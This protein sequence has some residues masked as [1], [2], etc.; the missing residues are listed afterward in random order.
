MSRRPYASSAWLAEKHSVTMFAFIRQHFAGLEAI[1]SGTLTAMLSAILA[2]LQSSA[3]SLFGVCGDD[4]GGDGTIDKVTNFSF[5]DVQP[6]FG[7]D[8][9]GFVVTP[10][11]IPRSLSSLMAA[12]SA[13]STKNFMGFAHVGIGADVRANGVRS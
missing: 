8:L 13:V 11:T 3:S 2:N 9:D 10:S 1:H 6:R 7:D 5:E 12:T 4:L